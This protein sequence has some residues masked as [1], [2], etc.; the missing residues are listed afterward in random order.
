MTKF[1]L[2]CLF[3]IL[4]PIIVVLWWFFTSSE[5]Q[6]VIEHLEMDRPNSFVHTEC[7]SMDNC[8]QR[9]LDL[10]N[11]MKDVNFRPHHFTFSRATTPENITTEY[12]PY[13]ESLKM[14]QIDTNLECRA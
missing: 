12:Q 3:I 10:L 4:L 7:I 8:K 1:S 11:H 9:R 13:T 6:T 5:K 14:R 2:T